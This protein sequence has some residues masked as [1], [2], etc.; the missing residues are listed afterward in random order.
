M[1]HLGG[2]KKYHF[3]LTLQKVPSLL[4]FLKVKV[5][6]HYNT[7]VKKETHVSIVTRKKTYL[8]I[9]GRLSCVDDG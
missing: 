1:G 9:V 2:H 4:T 3:F 8:S 5:V 6:M 7:W